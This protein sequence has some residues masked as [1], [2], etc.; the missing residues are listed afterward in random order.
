MLTESA[1]GARP[2]AL[3]PRVTA[4]QVAPR[5]GRRGPRAQNC[6]SDHN[7]WYVTS[8]TIDRS[9]EPLIKSKAAALRAP[10]RRMQAVASESMLGHR[11]DATAQQTM[12]RRPQPEGPMAVTSCCR[13]KAS[14]T[15]SQHRLLSFATISTR[16]R[17]RR[18]GFRLDQRFLKAVAKRF[19]LHTRSSAPRSQTSL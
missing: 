10:S 2:S 1:L 18:R 4:H 6:V 3:G 7:P 9:M 13:Y 16:N 15:M 14:S 11:R 17:D 12:R 5:A 8:R 19:T